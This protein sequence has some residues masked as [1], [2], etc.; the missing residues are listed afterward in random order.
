MI[1]DS[2]QIFKMQLWVKT[3]AIFKDIG[4]FHEKKNQEKILK[5]EDERE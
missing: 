1:H 5:I 4:S 3:N 2:D